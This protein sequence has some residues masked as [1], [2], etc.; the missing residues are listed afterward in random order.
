MIFTF[1]PR[2]RNPLNPSQRKPKL[3]TFSHPRVGKKKSRQNLCQK[4]PQ[5]IPP[6]MCGALIQVC[7]V[8]SLMI[9]WRKSIFT[10]D[11]EKEDGNG[12]DCSEESPASPKNIPDNIK[13]KFKVEM[14]DDFYEFWKFAKSLKGNNPAGENSSPFV[15]LHTK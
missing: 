1:L 6:D 2:N 14:P 8:L 15:S 5:V 12:A 9:E 10:T 3:T 7:G 13:S 11:E 4:S